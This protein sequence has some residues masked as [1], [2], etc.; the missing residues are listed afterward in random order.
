MQIKASAP[1]HLLGVGPGLFVHVQNW[2]REVER[3]AH[4]R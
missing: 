4:S 3:L 2:F 1:S